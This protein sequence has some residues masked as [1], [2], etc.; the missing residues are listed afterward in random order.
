[1][2]IEALAVG[3]IVDT[4]C[5]VN[6][7]MKLDEQAMKKY[8]KAFEKKQIALEKLKRKEDYTEKRLLNVVNKKR[9]I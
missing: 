1:M 2:I 7:S 8:G 9:T 5:K 3:A 6:K 4:V